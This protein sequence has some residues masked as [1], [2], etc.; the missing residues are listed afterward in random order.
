MNKMV[1]IFNHQGFNI[2]MGAEIV[3]DWHNFTA[4]NMPANHPA[5]DM[6]DTFFLSKD[7]DFLL[8]THTSSVQIKMM[9]SQ[10]PP[11]RIIS[12]GRVFRRDNDA[13]HSPVFH[14]V[15]GLY[16]GEGVSF[17]DLKQCLYQFVYEM[18]DPDV[19][20]KFRASF[21]PFTEPSAE[22]DIM[23]K[24][25]DGNEKWLEIFGCGM[26]DPAVL[27]NCGIDSTV[28]SGYAF[29]IGVERVAMLKYGLSDIRV[30]YE[31][32]IRFLKQFANQL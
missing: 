17:A 13:T 31:N 15:E 23:L 10:K 24:D 30:L 1:N 32:D 19:K 8:R 9:Q 27:E 28:Y 11:I 5:R 29:G 22:M 12:P 26:L 21:F 16:V 20:M 3:D 7:P 6:Q 14:Q 4:L 18:F 25:K 2:A